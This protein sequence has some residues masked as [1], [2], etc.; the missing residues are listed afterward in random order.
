[1][2]VQQTPPPAGP[3]GRTPLYDKHLAAGAE[4]VVRDGWE[5]PL[6][7]G[8][9]AAECRR[10]HE[11][12][13]VFDISHVGRIRI[14]GDGAL[15]ML[16][17]VCTH[18]V[19]RQEDDWAACTLLLNQRGGIVDHGMLVRLEDY[20]LLTC[21]PS[22]RAPVLAHLKEQAER[23]GARVDDQTGGTTM[24]CLAGPAAAGAL[25]AVLPERVSA[26]PRG[27][28]RLGSMMLARYIALRRGA[29]SLWS[30]EVVLPNMFAGPAWGYITKKAGPNAVAPA[31]Q[32]AWDVL[33]IEAG[34]PRFGCEIDEGVDPVTAGLEAALRP[35][36]GY[37]GAEAVAAIRAAGTRLRRVGLRAAG[38]EAEGTRRRAAR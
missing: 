9:V 36:G 13:G 29:T 26:L 23:F 2:P 34:L 3:P 24:V 28:G 8:E 14:R 33:R 30:L 27:A 32:A 6:R 38:Q 31:G 7:Y 15:D 16:E 4:M 22:R 12:A 35:E 37:L 20:W 17:H 11:R 10:V 19:A 21:S 18:D 1:M 5:M 25:D